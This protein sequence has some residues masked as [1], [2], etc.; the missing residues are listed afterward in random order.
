MSPR[1]SKASM[2]F[3]TMA[4]VDVPQGRNGKHKEIVTQILSDLDQVPA[5]TA[6]K[7]SFGGLATEQGEGAVCTE[8]RHSQGP[9]RCRYRQR[10]QLPV[11]MEQ[12]K[13]AGT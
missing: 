6:I 9:E 5:G 11:R 13:V 4:Q 12:G 2:H 8:S 10:R 3:P 1:A 7:V